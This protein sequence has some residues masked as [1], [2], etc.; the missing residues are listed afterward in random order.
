MS[1]SPPPSW[2]SIKTVLRVRDFAAS[3]RFYTEVLR[4]AVVEEWDAPEGK[5]CVF[6]FGPNTREGFLEIY[7]MTP[8]DRRHT[9]VFDESLANDKID[10]Q[11]G[12]DRLDEWAD[13]LT[14][15]WPFH[16]P[17]TTSWGQRWIQV[18]DPDGLL[19]ALYEGMDPGR[20]ME[21]Q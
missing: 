15:R 18:R 3:R 12:T 21:P 20:R 11:L 14:G 4:L 8:L 17:E 16:G 10:I 2:L 7:G 19:I 9:V 1:T 6:A 5:G 13:W